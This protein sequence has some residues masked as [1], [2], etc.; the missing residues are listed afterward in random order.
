MRFPPEYDKLAATSERALSASR[1]HRSRKSV[2][3]AYFAC[4]VSM[5]LT[6][7]VTLCCT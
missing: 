2:L 1:G 7:L 5:Y 4:R 6:R 3:P